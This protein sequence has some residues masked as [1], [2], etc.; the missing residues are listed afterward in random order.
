MTDKKR[1]DVALTERGLC[2][3]REKAQAAIMAGLVYRGEKRIE[4]ASEMVLPEDELT[5][6][7]KAQP[8][9]SRGGLKLE[10]AIASFHADLT[11]KVCM[12]IGCAT[13]GFT[14][15]CL[16]NGAS[17][18]YAIDVGYGQFDWNLRQDPRVTLMERTNARSLTPD[19]VPLHP[20]VTVMDVSFISIRLILPVAAEI[21][22]EN[23][24]VRDSAVHE[25]VL[26]NLVAFAPTFGWQ[27]KALDYSPIT[28]PKGNM[29]FLA[30]I[31]PANG[32]AEVCTES[33][34]HELVRQAHANLKK[35]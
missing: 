32:E 23:G 21:M 6:R 31:R 2:E 7:G 33:Y 17:H 13:G 25:E 9:A 35:E 29:E 10:K 27:V 11:D 22:G 26:R 24:V 28:G 8:Y 16:K 1:A 14:D 20:T 19:M 18:V 5:V 15:V 3:S 12:D 30:E 4:K 34:I